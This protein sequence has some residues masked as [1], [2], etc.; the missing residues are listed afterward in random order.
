MILHLTAR[1]VRDEVVLNL[2][3]I[4]S[5]VRE[6]RKVTSGTTSVQAPRVDN[7]ALQTTVR[8]RNGETVVL[9]GL[10]SSQERDERQ[11]LPFLL[12]HVPILGWLF[13]RPPALTRRWPAVERCVGT[14]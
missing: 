2:A 3:P 5:Q 12:K 4:L 11:G 6:I 7:R 1:I 8:L 13:G 14:S 9:G 10:I